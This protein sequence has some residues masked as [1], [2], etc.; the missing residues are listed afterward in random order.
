MEIVLNFNASHFLIGGNLREG[1]HGHNYFVTIKVKNPTI[2][3]LGDHFKEKIL[4]LSETLNNKV[5]IGVETDLMQ[6]E[7]SE[8]TI[9]IIFSD[10][11]FYLFPSE[12]CQKIPEVSSSAE[13]ISKYW[14]D[15]IKDNLEDGWKKVK[16]VLSE[17][18][19]QQESI[20]RVYNP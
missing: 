17:I 5:I 14:F 3:K 18:Y 10:N 6:I 4:K 16:I 7:E 1:L 9:K 15:L 2:Q 20:Y 11:S 13:C 8:D 12:E 19:L